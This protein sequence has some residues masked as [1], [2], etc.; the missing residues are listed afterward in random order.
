MLLRALPSVPDVVA[1]LLGDGR[2][3]QELLD[4]ADRLGLGDRVRF[5]GWSD[6][7]RRHLSTFDL[8]V[9]PSRVEAFPLVVVEAMLAGLPVVASEVGSVADAVVDGETGLLVPPDDA[10]ELASALRSLLGDPGRMRQMGLRGR[11]R[12]KRHFTSDAMAAAFESLYRELL[13]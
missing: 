9:V 6:E 5:L 7:P 12:A 1:V 13:A 11:E 10:D 2:S 3:R 4:L 8:C